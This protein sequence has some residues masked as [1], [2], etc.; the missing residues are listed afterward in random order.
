[1]AQSGAGE[2]SWLTELNSRQRE[3]ATHP[4]GPV[5]V[6]AGAGSGKTKT[7]A[8]RVAW[9]LEQG[10]PP[11]RI[12]LLTFTR[13]AAAEMLERAGR[14]TGPGSAGRVWGGTF[15]SMANRMLRQFGHSVG[16]AP[17]FTVIDQSDAADLMDLI[18]SELGLSESRRRFPQKGTLA[19]IYSRSVNGRTRV[20]E[21]VRRYFPWCEDS[22]EG[23]SQ[24]FQQYT[25]RKRRSLLLDYDDL[26]LFW[27]ALATAP[28]VGEIVGDR[29]DHILVD[30][31]QDTNS[32]QAEILLAMR[33]T[34][35][36][37]MVVG[38][39][40]Q[41]IY[42]FRAATVRNIL[43]FPQLFPGTTVV[44]LEE[45]YRSTQPI[46]DASNAV[47]AHAAERFEKDLFTRRKGSVLPTLI[48]CLDETEQCASVCDR[49]LARREEG[50][51]LRAQ[52]V[53]FRAG[54]NSDQLEV[55][56]SR[57]NVPFV[58]YGGLKFV[59]AAHVKDMLALV[60]LLE[61]PHDELSWHRVL[62]LLDGIG[63]ATARKIVAQLASPDVED[64]PA[65]VD[66]LQRFL[67]EAPAV[68]A[69]AQGEIASLREALADCTAPDLPI[70]SQIERIRRFY[71][72][73]FRRVYD[74]PQVRLRD[75]DSLE[76]ISTGSPSRAQFLTDLALDPPASTQDLAG[77]PLLDDDFLILSTVHSAKGSEWDAVHVIHVSDGVI[78]SDMATGSDEEIEEERR[79]LYVAMTRARDSL[80]LYFPLRYYDRPRGRGDRHSYAQLT[81]FIPPEDWH[82]Y[83]RMGAYV[84][85]PT[86]LTGKSET[87]AVDGFAAVDAL[88]NNL[89]D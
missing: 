51:P 53:L 40:A 13:R 89:W 83:E 74:N 43:D 57:R 55:E 22:L 63:P 16:L 62:Q 6:I 18:R 1:M 14:I 34:R 29:F 20:S 33:R 77:P 7:L 25:E 15:H 81:R 80:S 23:L 12:L 75:L 84:G 5:L 28:G 11:D 26:L 87:P 60:R 69:A 86:E 10:V 73:V 65:G 32:I 45:N 49:V 66:P 70:A 17:E 47:M 68:P 35:R 50:T 72:P 71:E 27:R 31:Y 85:T 21:V 24:V 4:G 88:L 58:K 37:L 48:T 59:E 9:L 78:P 44:K 19:A 41:A 30:E 36:D 61:N 3:A 46:L 64:R 56:L 54:H 42:S 2:Q 67:T 39:D 52:A 76:Q 38:D 79:L 82:L 8:C